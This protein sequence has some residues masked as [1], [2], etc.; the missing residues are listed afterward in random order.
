MN[1]GYIMQ[2]LNIW[3]I[4]VLFAITLH[5]VAHGW[6]A[7]KFG[8]R[9]AQMLGRLTLNPF[10]HID[11]IGTVLVPLTAFY[12]GGFIFG[13]AKPVPVTVQNLRNPKTNMLWVALAGP[14]ANFLMACFWTLLIVIMINIFPKSP[15]FEILILMG[16][17]GIIINVILMIFNLLPIP[18][19][20]GGRVLSSLLPGKYSWQLD[21]LEP[22]GIF[23]ILGLFA[24]GLLSKIISPPL[25]MFLRF[26][27]SLIGVN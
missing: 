23:I 17:A 10:N 25:Q 5:E 2:Q 16:K 22:Y 1:F 3:L 15:F 26:F 8:D 21:R 7:Y 19:L 13:W 24:L 9:T 14:F 27:Y 6:V 20:D 11:L 4:P 18:P 12:F